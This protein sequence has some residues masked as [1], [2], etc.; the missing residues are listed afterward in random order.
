[1]SRARILLPM[2][3]VLV[4]TIAASCSFRSLARLDADYETDATPPDTADA[5][6]RDAGDAAPIYNNID[7]RDFWQT[8]DITIN[9][10]L[11]HDFA[12]GTFDGH[13]VY[14]APFLSGVVARYD[15]GKD[16]DDP[17]AWSVFDT[18]SELGAQGFIGAV[19]DGQFVYFV[20]FRLDTV[21]HG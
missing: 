16:F 17:D 7:N 11:A 8:Y 6:A 14:F 4:G 21:L 12:G 9:K 10:P 20:P 19:F 2:S 13:Y 5:D 15:V 18:G 1:R 3:A